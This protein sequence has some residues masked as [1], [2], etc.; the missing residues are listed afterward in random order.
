MKNWN[1]V[2]EDFTDIVKESTKQKAEKA[3]KL[4]NQGNSVKDIS[5]KMGL[6]ES[7]IREY[8]RK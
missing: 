3:I 8:F 1:S 6:S 5:Y 2:K 4:K 7:R